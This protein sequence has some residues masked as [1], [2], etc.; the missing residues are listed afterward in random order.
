MSDNMTREQ[1]IA[2]T[3][4]YDAYRDSLQLSTEQVRFDSAMMPPLKLVRT[5]FVLQAR[6][7]FAF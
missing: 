4:A 1:F 2:V 5:P 6:R 3:A 7:R